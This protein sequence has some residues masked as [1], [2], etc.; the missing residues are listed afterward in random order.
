THYIEEAEEMADRVAVIDNGE[1]V[2][3]E[4]KKALMQKLGRKQLTLELLRK[5]DKI[6]PQLSAYN[7]ELT[8]DGCQL[9]FNYDINADRTGIT[10]MLADLHKAGIKFKDLNTRQSSLEEIFVSLVSHAK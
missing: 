6:P 10:A 4:D 1:I 5:I 7:L 9:L 8:S 2:I 3:V